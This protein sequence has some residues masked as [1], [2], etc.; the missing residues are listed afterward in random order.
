MKKASLK[1][2]KDDLAIF[3]IVFSLFDSDM[4]GYI[5]EEDVLAVII[6]MKKDA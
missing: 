3:E 2:V 5:P 1:E 6:S 4:E